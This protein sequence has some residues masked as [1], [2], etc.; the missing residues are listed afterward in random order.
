MGIFHYILTFNTIQDELIHFFKTRSCSLRI[1][2]SV[3]GLSVL[4]F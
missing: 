4:D 2:K 3:S 1:N